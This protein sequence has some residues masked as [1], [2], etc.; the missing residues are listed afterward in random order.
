MDKRT[1]DNVHKAYVE[2]AK[3]HVIWDSSTAYQICT[4]CGADRSPFQ[5]VD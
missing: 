4:V 3:A 1:A 2:E 5:S